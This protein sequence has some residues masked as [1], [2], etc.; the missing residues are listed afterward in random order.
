MSIAPQTMA[1][2]LRELRRASTCADLVEIRIDGLADLDLKKLLKRPRP[3]VI[4]TN[5]RVDEGGKFSGTTAEQFD[6]L[7]QA[8]R[9]GAEYIDVELSWGK[10]FVQDLLSSC[11]KTKVICSYHN[12]QETPR[13]IRGI[14]SAMRKTGADI[15]KLCTIANDISDNQKM[16][17]LT[18][19]AK[20]NRQQVISFCMG[21]M[22]QISRILGGK[23]GSYL[24]FGSTRSGT[25]TGVGQFTVEDL[26]K[27]FRVHTLTQRTK[28]FGL[29]GNPVKYSQGIYYH[30]RRFTKASM[31]AV[32]VNF[33]VHDLK[34]F[35]ITFGDQVSGLSITMPFKRDIIPL[36]DE[37]AEDAIPLQAVNTVIRRKGKLVGYN[38][39]LPAIA[40][41]LRRKTRLKNKQ[42]VVLG[43]GSTAKTMAYAVVHHGVQTTI[44][45]RSAEKAKA[46]ADDLDCQWATVD[47]LGLIPAD[48]LLNGTS[49]GMAA[50][51]PSQ[52]TLVPKR[53]LHR[54]MI[55]FEAVYNPPMTHLLRDAK[56]A[57]CTTISGMELFQR[58]AELQSKLF[59]ECCS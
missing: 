16:F 24:T 30:N 19:L 50:D 54:G 45:G 5:R 2:A 32:Y 49:V 35:F 18:R 59:L 17:N 22:G 31:D 1:D 29:V 55:V 20:T 36:L 53:Y 21:E 33:L 23:Y 39:D 47:N 15:L 3:N 6:I 46:L 7:S 56:S 42:A 8:I 14:Y 25:C 10:R 27:V 58:Q 40:S 37:V 38:T 28:V 26:K 43:T 41:L 9:F 13:D 48:I 12:F 11:S 4:I 44:V 52:R 57:G 34:Q 51:V